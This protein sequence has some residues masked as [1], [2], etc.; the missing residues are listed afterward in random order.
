MDRLGMNTHTHTQ[1]SYS[2]VYFYVKLKKNVDQGYLPKAIVVLQ[3]ACS[4]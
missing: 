2:K 4:L 1:K 3:S